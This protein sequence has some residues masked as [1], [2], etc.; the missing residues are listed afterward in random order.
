MEHEDRWTDLIQRFQG[1]GGNVRPG[2]IQTDMIEHLLNA[3]EE[4]ETRLKTAEERLLKLRK[5]LGE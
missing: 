1:R 3:L 5:D 2:S 4:V